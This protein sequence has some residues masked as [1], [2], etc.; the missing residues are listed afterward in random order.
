MLIFSVLGL[1]EIGGLIARTLAREMREQPHVYRAPNAVE[2][3]ATR[4]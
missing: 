3:T 2:G 1:P 4:R